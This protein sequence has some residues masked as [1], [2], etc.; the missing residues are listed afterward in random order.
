LVE[1]KVAEN[2]DL[3]EAEQYELNAKRGTPGCD[4]ES[5]LDSSL[6]IQL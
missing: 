4:R 2:T 3:S 6:A 5:T 1:E